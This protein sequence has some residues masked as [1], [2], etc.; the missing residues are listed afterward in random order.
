MDWLALAVGALGPATLTA[1]AWLWREVISKAIDRQN[2][3]ALRRFDQQSE[4]ALQQ[5][6][7]QGDIALA[8]L[9]G[10]IQ[11]A[12]HLSQTRNASIVEREFIA[13][14]DLYLKLVAAEETLGEVRAWSEKPS[15]T[16]FDD[17]LFLGTV[18]SL[19]EMLRT[20]NRTRLWLSPDT[21]AAVDVFARL[22]VNNVFIHVQ[23][24]FVDLVARNPKAAVDPEQLEMVSEHL[25]NLANESVVAAQEARMKV[26]G[27]LRTL[28]GIEGTLG[29]VTFTNE[30]ARVASIRRAAE[31]LLQARERK[32]KQ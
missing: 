15:S 20:A 21:W 24:G 2:E 18:V 9:N 25:A 5:V 12:T 19:A 30:L 4:L 26:E 28:V 7:Q 14:E 17:D 16:K 3:L 31:P 8:D 32:R 27:E 6:K 1:V 23:R 13:V 11:V 22:T 29:P 10:K